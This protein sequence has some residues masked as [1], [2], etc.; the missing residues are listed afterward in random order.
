MGS[1]KF[2]G[3]E[4]IGVW[5]HGNAVKTHSSIQNSASLQ[6]DVNRAQL[7]TRANIQKVS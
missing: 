3:N 4:I 1:G 6:L 2:Y 7:R 5:H